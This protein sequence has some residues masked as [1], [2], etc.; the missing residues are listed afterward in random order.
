MVSI[1]AIPGLTGPDCPRVMA[2]GEDTVAET[3]TITTPSATAGTSAIGVNLTLIDE[4][5]IMDLNGPAIAAASAGTTAASSAGQI[6][7]HPVVI[8][9]IGSAGGIFPILSIGVN[10]SLVIEIVCE[11]LDVSTT[12]AAIPAIT[13]IPSVGIDLIQ[14]IPRAAGAATAATTIATLAGLRDGWTAPGIA[15]IAGLLKFRTARIHPRI[16]SATTG[17]SG[18]TRPPGVAIGDGPV[19]G[20][21]LRN[22]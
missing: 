13:A 11:N 18:A 8:L 10:R 19:I 20:Q 5:E 9:S 15:R 21:R 12:I 6:L 17:S 7:Q 16:R 14:S 1:A 2:A 22:S 4:V 3:I